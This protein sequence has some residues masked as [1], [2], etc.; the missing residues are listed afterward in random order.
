M[1]LILAPARADDAGGAVV[2]V[3]AMEDNYPYSYVDEQGRLTGFGNEVFDAVARVMN[4][5]FTRVV[6]KDAQINALLARGEIDVSTLVAQR[7]ERQEVEEFSTPFLIL[8]GA[9]FVRK[10]D[11]RF[12]TFDD[13][14]R[15]GA[16]LETVLPGRDY[17]L[18][19]GLSPEQIRVAPAATA[20]RDLA[21]GRCDA[22]LFARF[23][24]AAMAQRL[25]LESLR[26]ADIPMDDYVLR[27]GFTVPRGRTHLLAQLNEGLAIIHKSGEFDEIYR[28]WFGRYEPRRFT[29]AEVEAY[30]AAV[31]A[32]ALAIALWALVRQRQLRHRIA[33][34]A[35]ELTRSR[36]ML[37]AAQEVAHLG[38]W[39]LEGDPPALTWSEETFRIFEREPGAGVPTLAELAEQFS[40]EDRVR[41]E[42][43]IRRVRTTG[44]D[45]EFDATIRLAGSR[46]KIVHLRI[47]PE[48]GDEARRS[49]LF[50]TVQD[51]TTWREAEREFQ[52][53]ASLLRV[54]YDHLPY[55]IG[56][57]E[58]APAGWRMVSCNPAAV[59]LGKLLA[60]PKPGELLAGLE[61]NAE[62]RDFF[63]EL[64]EQSRRSSEPLQVERHSEQDKRDYVLTLVPIQQP[65]DLLRCCFLVQDVTERK[66]KD[67]EVAQGR[68]LRAIGELVGGIAHE[69]N[70][71]LTPVLL[72]SEALAEDLRGQP[73]LVAEL[74]TISEAAR[75]SAELTRR[76]LTFG[77][78]GETHATA[79]SLAALIESNIDLLRH[80]I[81]R[82]IAL[83]ASAEADLPM[84]WANA[85]DLHQ[86]VLNL[87]LN[88]RD[89]LLERLSR[90]TDPEWRPHIMVQ[91]VRVGDAWRGQPPAARSGLPP[92]D[93]VRLTCRDNGMGMPPQVIERIFE[94]FYTTKGVGRGTGLG[95]AT[96]WHVVTQMGGH[97]DVESQV[98]AGTAFHVLLPVR[99]APAGAAAAAPPAASG[100]AAP[101]VPATTASPTRVLV[102]E[103]EPAIAVPVGEMLQRQGLAFDVARDGAEGWARFS[104]PDAGYTALLLDLNMPGLSGLE[105]VRRARRHAFTGPIVIMSGRVSREERQELNALGVAAIVAKPFTLAT[106]GQVLAQAGIRRPER[107]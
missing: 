22:A 32:V 44:R 3:G 73:A 47:C 58:L 104:A 46:H 80:T 17:A 10:G 1:G 59:A 65:G 62:R 38:H 41:W 88:A 98:G 51:V 101:A 78:R 106:L 30:V 97:I 66:R 40:P 7:P 61:M 29:P 55:A 67:A 95:L 60:L 79:V 75:R 70:N 21:E 36:A 71:L 107:S 85:N 99:P 82:R 14:R 18:A 96:V 45:F 35:E 12:E 103:D 69:F 64:L 25:G 57:V 49:G 91:A 90:E 93:W 105:L 6:G 63:I 42:E 94:P 100:E 15:Y 23:T 53:S 11:R 13:L 102:V 37:A 26:A 83:Q 39:R 5:K 81:D 89:T 19:R 87:L 16:R 72:K 68:R 48:H 77:R 28:K 9:V 92:V 50:G 43:A 86:I 84:L 33:R 34:Q 76:L 2:R 74:R 20:L 24:G 52:R 8:H 4:L 54:L 27:C 56:L 31:L